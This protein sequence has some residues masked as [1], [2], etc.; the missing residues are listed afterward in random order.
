M[1]SS[2]RDGKGET[3]SDLDERL[4]VSQLRNVLLLDLDGFLDRRSFVLEKKKKEWEEGGGRR[5]RVRESNRSTS[6]RRSSDQRREKH[7]RCSF[8]R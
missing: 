5:E 3:Y 4:V 2:T 1:E 7:V 8:H 6:P